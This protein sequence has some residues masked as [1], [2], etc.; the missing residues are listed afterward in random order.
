[1]WNSKVFIQENTFE[2]IVCEMAA[3]LSQ[4]QL[5]G[6]STEKNHW[7]FQLSCNALQTGHGIIFTLQWRHNE[8]GGISN[9]RGIAC[10]LNRLFSLRSKETSTLRVTGLCKGNPPVTGRFPS[11]KA[12]MQQMFPFDDTIMRGN[13]ATIRTI[14]CYSCHIVASTSSDWLI[15]VY[16]LQPG[17]CSTHKDRVL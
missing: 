11:Q 16:A 3:I 12:V 6:Y 5:I 13:V 4:P 10:L 14:I 2:N 1:M 17:S 8:R 7:R 15:W 9:H